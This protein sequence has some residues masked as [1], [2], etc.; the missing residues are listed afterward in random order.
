[1]LKLLMVLDAQTPVGSSYFASGESLSFLLRFDTWCSNLL[2]MDS[3]GWVRFCENDRL[4]VRL[5]TPGD[6]RRASFPSNECLSHP[7]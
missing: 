5:K 1:M 4:S 6:K 2:K 3:P 7:N